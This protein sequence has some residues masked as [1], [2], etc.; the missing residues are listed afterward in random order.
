MRSPASTTARLVLNPES[1]RASSMSSSLISMFVR[2]GGWLCTD[3]RGGTH[4]DWRAV[5]QGHLPDVP[6]SATECL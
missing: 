4:R 1:R 6:G 3:F 5:L 2:I